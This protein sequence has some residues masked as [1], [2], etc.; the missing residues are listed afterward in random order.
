[1]EHSLAG[2][3]PVEIDTELARIH[4]EIRNVTAQHTRTVDGLL[5][6]AGL[7]KY[8]SRGQYKVSGTLNDAIDLLE[9]YIQ[10]QE[11]W[12][13]S[14]Y[15]PALMPARLSDYAGIPTTQW[16]AGEV[17]TEVRLRRQRLDLMRQ[18]NEFN[19]EHERRPWPRYYVVTSSAGH[20]H[21]STGCQTCR[22]TTQFGWLPNMSGQSEAEAM[23]ALGTHAEALCSV[24]F[25]AA[26]VAGKAKVTKAKAVKLSAGDVARI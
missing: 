17:E 20:I 25:P 24:C 10:A 19:A 26:P 21:A 2:M 3:T 6:A 7:R 13:A 16:L 8:V 23:A 18:A 11:A 9:T 14:G 15:D 5:G 4:G 1:M 22:A 12:T